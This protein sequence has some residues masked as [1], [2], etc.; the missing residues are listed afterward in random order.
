[1][2]R[3]Y[4][5]EPA[6]LKLGDSTN[7]ADEMLYMVT[8]YTPEDHTSKLLPSFKPSNQLLPSKEG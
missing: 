4:Q 1:M 7:L 5:T 6:A 3:G 8:H 2:K